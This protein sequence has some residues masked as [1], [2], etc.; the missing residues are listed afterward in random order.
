MFNILRRHTIAYAYLLGLIGVLCFAA[1]LPLTAIALADFS[2][3]FITTIRA[4]IAAVAACIWI[5]LSRSTRPTRLEIKPLVVS[6]L[7]LIFGFP[8]AMAIGL[9]TV[10]SYHG[11]VVLGILPLVTAGLSAI[12]H[13]YRARIGFWLCAL[14]GAGLVILFTLKEQEGSVSWAD[15]WLV[16]AALMAS[17]GYVIAGDLAKR[18][19][20]PWVICW[21]LVLLSPISIVA[22]FMVWPEFF[23]VRPESSLLALLGLGFF[24]M[25]FGFFAWNTGLALG[26]IA[27]VGQVQLLQLFLTLL[28]GSILLGEVVTLDVWIFASLVALTVYVGRKLA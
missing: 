23:W 7:G 11:A 25:F 26:G 21:S 19:P 4:V 27:E 24:S 13:G 9:Q 16:L 22:T 8:L 5:T 14:A 18:R 6:G 15:L 1:T 3:T 28:W 17:S 2:P 12:V 20:G 10:P